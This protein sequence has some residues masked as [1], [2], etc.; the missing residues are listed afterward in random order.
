MT[1]AQRAI[2]AIVCSTI[3]AVVCAYLAA[4]APRCSRNS[5]PGPTIG[6]VLKLYGC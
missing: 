3:A 5:P 4:H 1:E 2:A 6:H